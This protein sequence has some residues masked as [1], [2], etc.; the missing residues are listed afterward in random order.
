MRPTHREYLFHCLS[1][2]TQGKTKGRLREDQTADPSVDLLRSQIKEA[3]EH[4]GRQIDIISYARVLPG[5][6]AEELTKNLITLRD[7]GLF[8]EIGASETNAA[9]LEA[10]SRLAPV[11]VVEIEVS[12]WTWEKDIQD[13]VVW[14]EKNK[15]PVFAYSPLGRGFLTR[16]WKT[17]EDI[18]ED[19]FQKTNPRFQGEAFYHN[20]KLV[21][22]LD[23]M[24][25]KK[26]LKTSQLAIAWSAGVNPYVCP[27]QNRTEG[28][29][30]GR[31]FPFRVRSTSSESRRTP[32][33]GISSSRPRTTRRWTRRSPNS[34]SKGLDTPNSCLTCSRVE[35]KDALRPF[36]IHR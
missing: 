28:G 36:L 22:Q 17:P 1:Q 32:K 8:R 11:S 16:K 24:A 6:T 34:K 19:Q 21:D 5:T 4:L 25:Q 12:L 26:G 31:T 23:A 3:E 35:A 7:E 15:V 9:S 20:L 2:R 14:S 30:D 27:F 29:A 10:M 18:P 33:R 13:V